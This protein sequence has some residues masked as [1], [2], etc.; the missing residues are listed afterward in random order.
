MNRKAIL[1]TIGAIGLA[2]TLAAQADEKK[3]DGPT[4]PP[5]IDKL[6]YFLGPWTIEGTVKAPAGGADGPVQG[7]ELCRWMP[8]KFFIGCMIETKAPT[9]QR[10]IQGIL[11]YDA[12]KKVYKWWS[13]DNLGHAET[14]TGTFKDGTWTW[15]G[16]ATVG[17]K[18]IKT[19]ET[20]SDTKPDGYSFRWETS[21]DGKTWTPQMTGKVAKMA[22]P[23]RPAA[24]APPPKKN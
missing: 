5:E 16:D 3:P 9:G 14:A 6:S 7:R 21:P 11:G 13:F 18:P 17:D 24:T 15:L 12:E 1:A 4:P 23:Q 19:R 20:F 22:T 2:A 8:G 10:Q